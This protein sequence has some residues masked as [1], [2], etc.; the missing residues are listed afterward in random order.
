MFQKTTKIG[1]GVA[2]DGGTLYDVTHPLD[3]HP[4]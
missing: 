2:V 1:S 4:W 3:V